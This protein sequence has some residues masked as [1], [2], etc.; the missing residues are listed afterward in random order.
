MD[1]LVLEQPVDHLGQRIVVAGAAAADR[2]HGA[3][4]KE[5]E[6][7]GPNPTDRGRPG[8]KRPIT[9]DGQGVP[10]AVRFTAVRLTAVPAHDR[11]VCE[12]LTGAVPPVRQRPPLQAVFGTASVPLADGVLIIGLGAVF[13]AILEVEKQLRLALRVN[14]AASPS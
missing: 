9:T 14:P 11:R 10:I 6:R 12:D 8:L 7:T 3:G 4:Q 1:H 2:R 5:G 13:F